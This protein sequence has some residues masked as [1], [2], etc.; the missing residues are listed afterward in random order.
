MY[1]RAEDT[2]SEASS[3]GEVLQAHEENYREAE[4]DHDPEL[5]EDPERLL[6]GS[7]S[8]SSGNEGSEIYD[9]KVYFI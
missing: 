4:D 2:A 3:D 8:E 6:S 7:M 1:A 9:N 5:D